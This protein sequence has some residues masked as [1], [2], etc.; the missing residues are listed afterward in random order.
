[1][2]LK[3]VHLDRKL[4]IFLPWFFLLEIVFWSLTKTSLKSANLLKK[5]LWQTCFPVNFLK[6]LRIPFL[7]NTAGR[8]LLVSKDILRKTIRWSNVQV[9]DKIRIRDDNSKISSIMRQKGDSQNGFYKKI[10]HAKFSDKRTYVC[11]SGGK[12][13]SFSKNLACFIFLEHPF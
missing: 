13:C 10:K 2:L 12:K 3:H 4:V 9:R 1:M 5:K 6:F 11:V 7:Q 8:L